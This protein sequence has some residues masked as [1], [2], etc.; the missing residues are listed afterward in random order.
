M[1]EIFLDHLVYCYKTLGTLCLS[2]NSVMNDKTWRD[3]YSVIITIN[4]VI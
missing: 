2:E 1:N 3:S 4:F